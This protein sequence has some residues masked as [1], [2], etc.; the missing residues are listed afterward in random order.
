[1]SQEQK[2][3]NVA[4]KNLSALSKRL[5]NY[6]LLQLLNN[7]PWTSMQSAG[8]LSKN[9]RL[10]KKKVP[11]YCYPKLKQWCKK[12][13]LTIVNFQN[14]H[15]QSIITESKRVR[16]GL[17]V[18]TLIDCHSDG[19]VP[20]RCKV[21][22]NTTYPASV[23]DNREISLWTELR[24]LELLMFSVLF[25]DLVHIWFVCSFWEPALFI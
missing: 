17:Y 9:K 10:D 22:I 7:F 12:V 3:L 16:L 18:H 20:N 24:D 19:Y 4:E 13:L 5:F 8:C 15:N 2:S 1:M 25:D 14:N 6:P 11:D 23:V 21:F